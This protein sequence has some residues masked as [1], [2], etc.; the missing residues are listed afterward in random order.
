M[1]KWD[2]E[3]KVGTTKRHNWVFH[4]T[5]VL[6][7]CVCAGFNPPAWWKGSKLSLRTSPTW[8]T[9]WS[10]SCKTACCR[11]EVR[12]HHHHHHHRCNWCKRLFLFYLHCGCIRHQKTQLTKKELSAIISSKIHRT[13][14]NTDCLVYY[15][16]TN[17]SKGRKVTLVFVLINV[18]TCKCDWA[19]APLPVTELELVTEQKRIHNI[20]AHLCAHM[21][22]KR[23]YCLCHVSRLSLS[24][25]L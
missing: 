3:K 24:P 23:Q 18:V 9:G 21:L 17:H 11:E 8:L 6:C 25:V 4:S 5:L 13:H 16:L 22:T 20:W 7:V 19:R 2:G 10:R 15:K 14:L 1:N 12:T